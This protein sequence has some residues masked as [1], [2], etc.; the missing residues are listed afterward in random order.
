MLL[1]ENQRPKFWHF[2]PSLHLS[3]EEGGGGGGGG[4][5]CSGIICYIGKAIWSFLLIDFWVTSK[6]DCF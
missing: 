1:K 6:F 2:G 3:R 4:G 5:G